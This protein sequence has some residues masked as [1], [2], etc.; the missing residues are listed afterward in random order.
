MPNS[1]D[2]SRSAAERGGYIPGLPESTQADFL[3]GRMG[4]AMG[5]D[6]TNQVMVDLWSEGFQPQDIPAASAADDLG[7]YCQAR[8]QLAAHMRGRILDEYIQFGSAPAVCA[9]YDA[10]LAKRRETLLDL[11]AKAVAVRRGALENPGTG[12]VAMDRFLRDPHRVV[13]VEAQ[14]IAG[15]APADTP[16]TFGSLRM[17]PA[18]NDYVCAVTGE[19]SDVFVKF[20][21][22]SWEDME[23][24]LGVELPKILQGWQR[25]RLPVKHCVRSRYD[26]VGMVGTPIEHCVHAWY[27]QEREL[28]EGKGLILAREIQYLS[29]FNPNIVIAFSEKGLQK[30]WKKLGIS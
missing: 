14:E 19:A 18:A 15:K 28:C 16:A 8:E 25:F 26:A 2:L 27:Q 20:A 22:N 23:L 3:S 4:F 13:V 29:A 21:L 12:F 30:L 10:A 6:N 9:W 11:S 5:F 17:S 7:R 24:T 1:S